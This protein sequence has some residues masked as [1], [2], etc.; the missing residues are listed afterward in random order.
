MFGKLDGYKKVLYYYNRWN[1]VTIFLRE[2][3]AYKGSSGMETLKI[4]KV[5]VRPE[6]YDIISTD[7]AFYA[8]LGQ[9]MYHAFDRLICD[10]DKEVFY[11][12]ARKE[13]SEFF[14]MH[15]I[16]ECG[17]ISLWCARV[18]PDEKSD[19]LEVEVANIKELFK[20]NIKFSKELNVKNRMLDLYGD[21]VFAYDVIKDRVV[22]DT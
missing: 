7:T 15:M 6:T 21:Y 12:H 17:E 1:Y 11:E 5:I 14:A 18:N 4:H 10:E 2:C 8:F 9:R 3:F 13:D 19:R 16:D 22:I 20:S